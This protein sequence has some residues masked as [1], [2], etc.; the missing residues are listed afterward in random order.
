K[1]R[2]GGNFKYDF[3]P[4]PLELPATGRVWVAASTMPPAAAGDV[5]EDDAVI[6][7]H[8]E[9]LAKYPHLLL[10]LSPRKP[11]HFDT[12]A[13]KLEQ[14]GLSYVRRTSMRPQAPVKSQTPLPSVLLL[15][16]IGE[17]AGLFVVA[18]VVFMGGT[19]AQRG[20]HN[21]LEPAFFGKPVITGPHMENFHAIAEEFRAAGALVEIATAAPLAPT[22]AQLLDAPSEA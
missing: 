21:I 19:L 6:A 20:G 14:A 17:L 22:V 12:A 10:I 8:R 7:A 3:T 11:Q 13:E 9:L 18:D 16:T 4:Q 15:D 2:T 1:V 5:D